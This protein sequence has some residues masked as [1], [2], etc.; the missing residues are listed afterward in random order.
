MENVI[1]GGIVDNNT[2]EVLW[3]TTTTKHPIGDVHLKLREF[4]ENTDKD[5]STFRFNSIGV[6]YDK[7]NL[8]NPYEVRVLLLRY[9]VDQAEKSVALQKKYLAEI[10]EAADQ[11]TKSDLSAR[12]KELAINGLQDQDMEATG[13]LQSANSALRFVKSDLKKLEESKGE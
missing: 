8:K 13:Y 1:L 3:T 5:V 10:E 11:I 6:P 12:S 7:K 4:R 9:K 2:G